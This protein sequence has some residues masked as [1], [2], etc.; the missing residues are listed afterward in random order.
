MFITVTVNPRSQNER[1]E[2]VDDKNYKVYFNVP[3][4]KGR[5]NKRVIKL[6]ADYLEVPKSNISIKLGRTAREKVLEISK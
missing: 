6:M 2:K 3:P 4:E 1:V 5:A